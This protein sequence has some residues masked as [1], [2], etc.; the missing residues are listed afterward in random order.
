MADI[1]IDPFGDHDKT[2]KPTGENTLLTTGGGGGSIWEPEREQETS[3]QGESE[4]S[5]EENVKEL[6]QLLGNKT[7]QRLEPRLD[8]FKLGEDCKLYYRGKPLMNR[9]GKLKTISVIADTLGIRGLREMGFKI[10]ETNLKPQHVLDLL[11][12]KSSY[13]LRLT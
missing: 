8:L 6:Y 13:L 4:I 1:D 5:I 11:E 3:I 9:N 7:H 12:N 2:D 10:I